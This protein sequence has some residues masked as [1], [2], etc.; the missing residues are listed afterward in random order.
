MTTTKGKLKRK[1]KNGKKPN[2][3]IE[4]TLVE[5]DPL[6]I[7]SVY[8]FIVKMSKGYVAKIYET[9]LKSL[10]IPLD[11]DEKEVSSKV[12]DEIHPS[13]F[14]PISEQLIK[15]NSYQ[16]MTNAVLILSKEGVRI[17][18]QIS[19]IP[20]NITDQ[21]V[22]DDSLWQDVFEVSLKILQKKPI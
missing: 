3:Q 2:K 6:F 20:D 5:P 10:G 12:L 11:G 21:L 4:S 18:L 9:T 17:M 1:I 8:P 19:N 7:L 13:L 22:D 14:G 15:N 16:S